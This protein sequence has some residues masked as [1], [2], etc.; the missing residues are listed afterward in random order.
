MTMDIREALERVVVRIDLERAEMRDVMRA[1][2][3]GQCTPAQIGGFLVGLRMKGESIDEIT[4]AAEVMRELA[5]PVA[6]DVAPLVDVVGTGGDGANL[7]NVS[8]ASAFVVAAAGGYVAKHGNRGV[9]SASGSAD[10]LEQLGVRVGVPAEAVARGVR[11]LGI[12]F[13]FAPAHHSA[14]RHALGARREL[15]LRT[16]FN[17]LGPLTN[18]AGARRLLIGVFT[19]RLCRPMAEVLGRLGAERVMVVHAEDGL[20]EISLATRTHVVELSDGVISEYTLIPED[21]GIGSQSLIG[22]E[23][24]SAAESAALIR[25]AL[26][27]RRGPQ[28]AKAADMIALNAGP[29]IYLAGIAASPRDGVSM[30][31][32]II[33]AGLAG[34]RIEALASFT[35][36]LEPSA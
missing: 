34:E 11:E 27:K 15:G 7:F 36:C 30:A 29:A 32:D 18:P 19:A 22:L 20:D 10:V 3:S 16:L 9:S 13:M 33:H 1:I 25:D 35:A 2:M 21:L 8:T 24:A 28:A 31:N 23:V 6:I 14:M 12:G 17:I 5:T 26:G 4:A